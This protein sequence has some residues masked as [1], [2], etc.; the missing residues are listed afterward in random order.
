MDWSTIWKR[1]K[2]RP[3]LRSDMKPDEA[4]TEL[5]CRED[6][7]VA[8]AQHAPLDG[9]HDPGDLGLVT[10][11][12]ELATRRRDWPVA[13]ARWKNIINTFDEHLSAKAYVRAAYAF[14]EIGDL[15]QADEVASRGLEV[16]KGSAPLH[17]ELAR[18]AMAREDWAAAETNW[19]QFL[20][21]DAHDDSGE[22][23]AGLAR[24]RRNAGDLDGAE[25]TL[26]EA[27]LKFP[28][29]VR[30]LAETA[31]L[32]NYRQPNGP[33]KSESPSFVPTPVEIVICVY[34]ALGETTNCLERLRLQTKHEQFVT[35]VDDASE[36]NVRALLEDFAAQ[37]KSW[38]LL[39]NSTNQGY[40]GSANKGLK[41]ARADWVVL[42]NSDTLVPDGWLDGLQRCAL[43][44]PEIRAVGPLSNSATFQSL[45]L[46]LGECG[47]RVPSSEA[48]KRAAED[49]R[50][51]S[52][53]AFPKVPMLNG[54]CLML[55]KPTLE[56]VGYLDETNFPRGY[57]EENDLCLR[58]LVGGH[59]LAIADDVFVYHARSTS[60]GMDQRKE[61]SGK[62]VETLKRLWPG[63]SYKYISEVIA[64]L[65]ALR[66]LKAGIIG[67]RAN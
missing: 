52:R 10:E 65:P 54:F 38:R 66:Q 44:D 37:R 61:L 50:K 55:H 59:K 41:A 39:V 20:G 22:A 19:N 56:Q 4:I 45:A 5:S 28:R 2:T 15:A 7:A 1:F 13:A 46:R 51:A 8:E 43:S 53:A 26:R 42:L 58:L 64:E 14:R 16:H 30:L 49:V 48:L 67:Q 35:I 57:G 29:D 34:N 33:R 32:E 27:R 9:V 21:K 25:A 62:A 47:D 36:P 11:L 6:E 17:R 23:Y 18:S 12:A 60:F 63:Y 40:T 3:R 31:V 24:S